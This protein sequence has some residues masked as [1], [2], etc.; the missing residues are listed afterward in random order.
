M[1]VYTYE[2]TGTPCEAG[3]VIEVSQSMKDAPLS[4]CPHCQ[5]PVHKVLSRIFISTPRGN[6]SLK[7]LGFTKLVKRDKGVYEN[8]TARNGDSR[9]VV[10]GKENTLPNLKKT[11]TD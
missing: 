8:V 11:I 1:P 9:Y 5:G 3:A 10:A 2:H 6:S 4:L 7:D